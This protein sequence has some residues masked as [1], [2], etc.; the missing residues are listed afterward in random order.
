MIARFYLRGTGVRCADNVRLVGRP[1]VHNCGTIELA[2]GVW[3]ISS[4]K[5]YGNYIEPVSLCTG[6]PDSY[7]RLRQGAVLIGC[8]VR[9][10]Y[11][12]TVGERTVIA[13]HCKIIDHDHHF[14]PEKRRL[15]QYPGKPINIGRDVWI[16]FNCIVLK[17]VTIGDGSIIAAG[18]V[19]T[20]DI[21]PLCIAGGVPARPLKKIQA[22]AETGGA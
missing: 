9:A 3:L 10:Y 14:E 21:D 7:I 6:A 22:P 2:E 5:A 18:S 12:L 11:G 15:P 8:L 19:V 13:P 16:G 17:G 4:P 20:H 1:M